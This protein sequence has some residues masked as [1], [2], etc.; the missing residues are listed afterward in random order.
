[1]YSFKQFLREE[2]GD[3]TIT[4]E[5]VMAECLPFI[6]ESEDN[7]IYRG[8]NTTSGEMTLETPDG[9]FPLYRMDVRQ[10]RR[11]L[12]SDMRTHNTVDDFL[13]REFGFPGRSQGLFVTG[14]RTSA[15]TY[16]P[17]YIILPRG[18]FRYVWSPQVRDLLFY[19]ISDED[20]EDVVLRKLNDMQYQDNDL[21]EAIY[22]HNEIMIGCKDYY[23]I[24]N[25][26]ETRDLINKY[27]RRVLQ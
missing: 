14:N 10:D 25:R 1:M 23:A 22:S 12:H 21:P 16:G 24:P 9:D 19:P 7:L 20:S 2:S 13:K 15:S 26:V 3:I 6:R 5:D 17:T 8:I 27:M 4:I 11:P 18:E